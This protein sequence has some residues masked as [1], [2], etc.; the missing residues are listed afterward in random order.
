MQHGNNSTITRCKSAG[1]LLSLANGCGGG[2]FPLLKFGN[3]LRKREES[4]LEGEEQKKHSRLELEAIPSPSSKSSVCSFVSARSESA[5][6]YQIPLSNSQSCPSTTGKRPFL[7]DFSPKRGQPSLPP[8]SPLSTTSTSISTLQKLRHNSQQQQNLLT[9]PR[10]RISPPTPT[11]S[12]SAIS[13]L[14]QRSLKQLYKRYC[15]RLMPGL[16]DKE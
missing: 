1:D 10:F 9:I 3:E 11:P 2:S 7:L 4:A 13:V 5:D 6:F 8:K 12:A 14:S 16:D 15:S